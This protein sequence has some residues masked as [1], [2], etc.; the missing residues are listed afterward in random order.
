MRIEKKRFAGRTFN[1]VQVVPFMW[2][3]K[4]FLIFAIP[5]V[6]MFYWYKDM[7]NAARAEDGSS[8]YYILMLVPVLLLLYAISRA[9]QRVV[10]YVDPQDKK[11]VV[12]KAGLILSK[13]RINT[14]LSDITGVN[15]ETRVV[16]DKAG[17][18]G[19]TVRKTKTVIEI[20]YSKGTLKLWTYRKAA[21]AQKAARLIEQL[22]KS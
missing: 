2:R 17:E 3:L 1:A 20:K 6:V 18:S 21:T 15:T 9:A 8:F 10:V 19:D 12:V 13:E 22:L 16:Y 14:A 11:F 5:A 4:R 7:Y